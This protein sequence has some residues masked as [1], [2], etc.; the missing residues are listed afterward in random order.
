MASPANALIQDLETEKVTAKVVT[1][2]KRDNHGYISGQLLVDTRSTNYLNQHPDIL[3][4]DCT[5][6]TNKF[7]MP[8]VNKLGIDNMGRSFSVAFSFLESGS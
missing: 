8:L 6:K 5:Y 4:L 7:D 2:C 3:L 1:N